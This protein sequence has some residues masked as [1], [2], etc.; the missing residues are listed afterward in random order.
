MSEVQWLLLATI[1]SKFTVATIV[2]FVN[3]FGFMAAC[4]VVKL[5]VAFHSTLRDYAKWQLILYTV[6]FVDLNPTE[7]IY[8]YLPKNRFLSKFHELSETQA[9]ICVLTVEVVMPFAVIRPFVDNFIS[10]DL[11]KRVSADVPKAC[12]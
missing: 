7:K 4:I 12:L 2:H 3:T 5:T 8:E 10:D 1:S 6:L 9:E 11:K